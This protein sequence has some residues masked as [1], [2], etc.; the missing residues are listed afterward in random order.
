MPG[1][2]AGAKRAWQA[3]WRTIDRERQAEVRRVLAIEAAA[4]AA[5]GEARHNR[6]ALYTWAAEVAAKAGEGARLRLKLNL[7]ERTHARD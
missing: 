3:R 2:S 7:M 5:S 4:T 6:M 1:T